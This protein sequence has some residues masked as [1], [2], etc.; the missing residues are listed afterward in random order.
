MATPPDPAKP[1]GPTPKRPRLDQPLTWVQPPLL[2]KPAPKPN[3]A[4]TAP[5]AGRGPRRHHGPGG[6][7]SEPGA[8]TA[9][10]DEGGDLGATT[11]PSRFGF[12]SG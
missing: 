4:T 8:T 1:G 5:A 11:A 12:L 9:P 3:R 6:S 2:V 7:R 10:V